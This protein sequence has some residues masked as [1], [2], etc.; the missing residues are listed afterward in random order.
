MCHVYTWHDFKSCCIMRRNLKS[1]V[2]NLIIIIILII[3]AFINFGM[4]Y[5]KFI[6]VQTPTHLTSQL[7]FRL[8]VSTDF[9]VYSKCIREYKIMMVNVSNFRNPVN[10]M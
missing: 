8:T 3:V 5:N 10:R 2:K 9:T 4:Q 6:S 1:F 7:L